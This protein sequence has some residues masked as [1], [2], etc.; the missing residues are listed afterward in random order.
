MICNPPT[1]LWAAW[2]TAGTSSARSTV[3]ARM[4]PVLPAGSGVMLAV[5]TAGSHPRRHLPVGFADTEG[6]PGNCSFGANDGSGTGIVRCI[7]SPLRK[8]KAGAGHPL[9]I[10][11]AG[12]RD[13]GLGTDS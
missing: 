7:L 8:W 10:L 9:K 2:R 5:G 6:Q 12:R 3:P 11:Q 1:T 13:R 4:T